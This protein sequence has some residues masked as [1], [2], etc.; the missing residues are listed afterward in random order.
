MGGGGI[1]L[2]ACLGG[3]DGGRR[4]SS[5]KDAVDSVKGVI[6]EE[7]VE[8]CLITDSVDSGSDCGYLASGSFLCAQKH[9][10]M[11]SILLTY[12]TIKRRYYCSAMLPS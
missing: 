6:G 8:R 2:S 5:M 9:S 4:K 10:Q 3:E 12:K 11:F 7:L 1:I